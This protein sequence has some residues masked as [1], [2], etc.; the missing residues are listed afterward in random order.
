FKRKTSFYDCYDITHCD[1]EKQT[2]ILKYF[3]TGKMISCFKLAEKWA[4]EALQAAIEGLEKYQHGLPE[5]CKSCA[6][7]TAKKMGATDEQSLMVAGFAG[8]LGLSGNACGALSAAIWMHT[9]T[10][11]IENPGKVVFRNPQSEKALETLYRQTNY[12]ILCSEI[13]GTTFNSTDEH[14]AYI[15]HGGCETLMAVLANS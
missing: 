1:W 5:K 7:E 11:N 13:T 9:M 3:V 12:E 4:P 6:T 8:G 2:S 15:E 14:T 10:F